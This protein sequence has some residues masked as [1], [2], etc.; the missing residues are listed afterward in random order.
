MDA[1]LKKKFFRINRY[2]DL[3]LIHSRSGMTLTEVVFTAAILAMLVLSITAS[4]H[5]IN[6]S[7][8]DT[9]SNTL[10]TDKARL[11][12]DRMVWGRRAVGGTSRMAISEATNLNF[13]SASQLSYRQG[14][15]TWHS[16]RQNGLNIEYQ[17]DANAAWQTIYDPDGSGSNDTS[18]FSTSLSFSQT[19]PNA[20]IINLRLGTMYQGRWYYAS[21]ST[22]VFLRNA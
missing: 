19:T 21:S 18:H 7:K 16:I 6:V 13:N 5:M 2:A 20:V 8:Y 11:L 10:M 1:G 3:R 14:T 12:M 9:R 15:A 22:Q 17:P 4:A